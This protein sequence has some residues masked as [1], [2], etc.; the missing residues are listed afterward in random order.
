MELVEH[1][2]RLHAIRGTAVRVG[3]YVLVVH[4]VVVESVSVL[5]MERFV[6]VFA[7]HLR[8]M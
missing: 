6:V 5:T 4:L 2:E 7:T 1:F 3:M 8:V